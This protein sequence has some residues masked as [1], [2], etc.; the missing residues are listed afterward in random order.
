MVLKTNG[1][2]EVFAR[3]QDNELLHTWQLA[4]GGWSTWGS[5]GGDVGSAPEVLVNGAGRLEAFHVADS[6]SVKHIWQPADG[7]WSDWSSLGGELADD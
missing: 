5:L 2:L 4:E 6:G 7:G 3:G 1:R